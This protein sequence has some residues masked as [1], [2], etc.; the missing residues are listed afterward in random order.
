MGDSWVIL[1][2]TSLT[3]RSVCISR[4]FLPRQIR[5]VNYYINFYF[6][7]FS[8]KSKINDS[9]QKISYLLYPG[10][11]NFITIWPAIWSTKLRIRKSTAT[12]STSD[13]QSTSSAQLYLGFIGG[14]F[15]HLFF[16]LFS[17]IK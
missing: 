9:R 11:E 14:K 12:A 8:Q 2:V 4:G 13:N 6:V 7:V 17:I 15:A 10:I 3:E 16:S 1:S 5:I